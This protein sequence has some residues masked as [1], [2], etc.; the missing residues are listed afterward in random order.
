MKD[1][2][3]RC[4]HCNQRLTAEEAEYYGGTCEACEGDYLKLLH[5]VTGWRFWLLLIRCWWRRITA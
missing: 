5:G 2:L 1:H 3:E 4:V